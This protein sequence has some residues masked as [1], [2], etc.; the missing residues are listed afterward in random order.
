MSRWIP[1]GLSP[2]SEG[3]GWH[4]DRGNALGIAAIGFDGHGLQ[5]R[6]HR[7][8]FHRS[9]PVCDDLCVSLPA[10]QRGW[11]ARPASRRDGRHELHHQMG[12]DHRQVERLCRAPSLGARCGT[13]GP[14]S[15]WPRP[16]SRGVI[17][18]QARQHRGNFREMGPISQ[19]SG[20]DPTPVD[21]HGPLT[22][23]SHRPEKA[24][25]RRA[26]QT[27]GVGV[28]AGKRLAHRAAGVEQVDAPDGAGGIDGAGAQGR[29]Q[30]FVLAHGLIEA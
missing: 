7:A 20:P 19:I 9:Q 3:V 22:I 28:V 14:G 25:A 24:P 27:S 21:S 18:W 15:R 26:R 12:H 11:P 4:P 10:A 5:D 1:P 17:N 8:R 23:L 29:H 2:C 16:R 13:S 6:L 30:S